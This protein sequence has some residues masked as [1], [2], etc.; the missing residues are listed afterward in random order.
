MDGGQ[1]WLTVG[2]GLLFFDFHFYT[3]L[4]SAA[5]KTGLPGLQVTLA[6]RRLAEAKAQHAAYRSVIQACENAHNMIQE[7]YEQRMSL[8]QQLTSILQQ[9]NVAQDRGQGDLGR[10]APPFPY[11]LQSPPPLYYHSRPG[12]NGVNGHQ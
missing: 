4:T 2:T 8:K 7:A 10:L 9:A 5:S 6:D 11:L 1:R 12:T 3:G